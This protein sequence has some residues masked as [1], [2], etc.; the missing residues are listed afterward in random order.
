MVLLAQTRYESAI[1]VAPAALVIG[2][3]WWREGRV[4]IGPGLIAAP[5][6]LLPYAWQHRMVAENPVL[7][8]LPPDLVARFGWQHLDANITGALR[9]F[10][11]WRDPLQANSLLVAAVGTLGVAF[12]SARL[13]CGGW[14]FTREGRLTA[15]ALA[16]FGVAVASNGVLLM[17][18]YWGNLSD[19]V[20]A[21]LGLPL[22]A[23]LIFSGV[24]LCARIGLANERWS[25]PAS[26]VIAIFIVGVTRPQMAMRHYTDYNLMSQELEWEHAVVNAL[27]PSPRLVI[28]NKS[29][30]PWIMRGFQALHLDYARRRVPEIEYHWRRRTFP[31]VIVT[32]FLQ[33]TGEGG[34]FAVPPEQRLP[35]VTLSAVAERRFGARLVR[36]S[37]IVAID[38]PAASTLTPVKTR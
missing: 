14:D 31:E 34:S 38:L 2:L 7:W 20:V 11:A 17:F 4:T 36:V 18:Y 21:R 3:V 12:A 26:V 22:L 33:A 6:L 32:Q 9:F 28:S 16:I 13:L 15:T 30:L 27:P 29:S 8:E 24:W 25:I 10:F 23:W 5:I 1:Y 19:P 35:G 37:R